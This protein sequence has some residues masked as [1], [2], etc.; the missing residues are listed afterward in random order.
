[1]ATLLAQ[2]LGGRIRGVGPRWP[3]THAADRRHGAKVPVRTRRPTTKLT[4]CYPDKP[5]NPKNM[6][7]YIY[8]EKYM[9]I[10]L[11]LKNVYA[12]LLRWG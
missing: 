11:D 5:E 7:Y 9:K 6:K 2:S 4:I 3:Q 10:F 1:M 12:T 8:F